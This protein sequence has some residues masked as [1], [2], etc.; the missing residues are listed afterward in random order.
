MYLP[1]YT[2]LLNDESHKPHQVLTVLTSEEIVVISE[3]IDLISEE[4]VVIS[5]EIVLPS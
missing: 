4:I 2:Y 3:K 5:E 1:G